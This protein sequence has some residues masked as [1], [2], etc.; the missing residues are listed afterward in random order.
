[1]GVLAGGGA[2]GIYGVNIRKAS[3]R[4]SVSH[5]TSTR[6]DFIDR[7]ETSA[8]AAY[9]CWHCDDPTCGQVTSLASK[10]SRNAGF[11][12]PQFPITQ[13]VRRRPSCPRRP[14]P[15][16]VAVESFP[17]CG[18]LF[19]L[20]S[21]SP[22]I[23]TT[24]RLSSR[25][26]P[27]PRR[28]K[29]QPACVRCYRPRQDRRYSCLF[30]RSR[31]RDPFQHRCRQ[32]PRGWAVDRHPFYGRPDGQGRRPARGN[33]PTSAGTRDLS[34]GTP[35]PEAPRLIFDCLGM[36]ERLPFHFERPMGNSK[37]VARRP[38]GDAFV[39]VPVY[40]LRGA[41]I[42]PFWKRPFP[43]WPFSIRKLSPASRR[44]CAGRAGASAAGGT[45]PSRSSH[46]RAFCRR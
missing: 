10:A 1:M 12:C 21:A 15:G 19:S 30:A 7:A 26:R 45:S 44:P 20:P 11:L 38:L 22:A 43:V 23:V 27:M 3:H 8:T 6:R 36:I 4:C 29:K 2:P 39:G 42:R 31:Q 34:S 9:I 17:S 25:N 33:R 32:E 14:L 37:E 18:S 13:N 35:V 24:K 40:E 16:A 46:S 41:L 28:R 5:S